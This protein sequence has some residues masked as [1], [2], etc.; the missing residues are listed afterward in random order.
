MDI[1]APPTGIATQ[2]INHETHNTP[3]LCGAFPPFGGGTDRPSVPSLISSKKTIRDDAHDFVLPRPLVRYRSYRNREQPVFCC[4]SRRQLLLQALH[5]VPRTRLGARRHQRR[6]PKRHDPARAFAGG[7]GTILAHCSRRRWLL[8]PDH[9]VP[10]VHHVL[11]IHNG[12]PLNDQPHLAQCGNFSGQFWSFTEEG[13]R[14]R[15]KT[16]FRGPG[17]CLD[18]FNG[19]PATSRIL[20]IA[21]T[22]RVSSGC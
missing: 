4:P 22:S 13:G 12:G 19:G 2:H 8:P 16:Q 17:Q 7:D 5:R 3:S 20:P 18:I 1:Q 11:C 14:V 9:A 6:A 10:R 15:L 21:Q